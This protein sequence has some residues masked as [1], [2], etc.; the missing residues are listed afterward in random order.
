MSI[1]LK[2]LEW[3]LSLDTG[4]MSRVNSIIVIIII[5]IIITLKLSLSL[6]VYSS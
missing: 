4:I 3:K 6:V 1:T 2:I 5:I